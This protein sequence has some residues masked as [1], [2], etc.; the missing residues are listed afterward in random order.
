MNAKSIEEMT[1]EE[2]RSEL[3]KWN[4]WESEVEK[5]SGKNRDYALKFLEEL[6]CIFK[7]G[8]VSGQ[9][10]VGLQA[11]VQYDDGELYFHAAG[12]D[13]ALLVGALT[14]GIYV[15]NS[16]FNNRACSLAADRDVS[17]PMERDSLE[18]GYRFCTHV[19]QQ[20]MKNQDTKP[21]AEF[22]TMMNTDEGS[23]Q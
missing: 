3:R 10:A 12:S 13:R 20:S 7:V 22:D 1:E 5:V 21:D 15:L 8:T 18:C 16:E 4:E 6:N 2:L 19:M 17:F 14:T 23:E 9:R 11:V